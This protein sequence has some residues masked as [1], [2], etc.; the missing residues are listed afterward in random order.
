MIE[1]DVYALARCD[2]SCGG[3][4]G[5]GAGL[6]EGLGWFRGWRAGCFRGW[7]AGWF[8]DRPG[9]RP[10]VQQSA[11]GEALTEKPARSSVARPAE[12]DPSGFAGQFGAHEA[13]VLRVCR[14][15]LGADGAAE[16]ARAEVFLRARRAFDRYDPERPFRPWLLSI[17]GHYCIDQLRRLATEKRVFQD[18]EPTDAELHRSPAQEAQISPLSRAVAAQERGAVS[19]AIESLPLRYRLPLVLRYFGELDYATIAVAL[20]VTSNQVGSLLFRAKRLLRERLRSAGPGEGG[21]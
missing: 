14:R 1:T 7:R 8:R 18:G 19:R 21:S 16:D 20:G 3:P 17:A 11:Q 2:V 12:R 5:W 15:M 9:G 4:L 10:A 13:D 6:P